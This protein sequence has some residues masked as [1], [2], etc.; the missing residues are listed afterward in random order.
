MKVPPI[1]VAMGSASNGPLLIS[2]VNWPILGETV[3]YDVLAMRRV[4]VALNPHGIFDTSPTVFLRASASGRLF[5][6]QA[7]ATGGAVQTC[8]W[9]NGDVRRF[10][11]SAGS[12]PVPNADNKVVFTSK[13]LYGPQLEFLTASDGLCIPAQRGGYYARLTTFP[14]VQQRYSSTMASTRWT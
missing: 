12:W 9:F 2:G 1:A 8:V 11:A 3:F 6:C 10:A 13:G 4:N 7:S 5:A 14:H